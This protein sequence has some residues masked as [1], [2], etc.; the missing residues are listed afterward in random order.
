MM[1]AEFGHTMG[2][3]SLA[4][5]RRAQIL[6]AL[7]TCILRFGLAGST[8]GRIA[9]EAGVQPSVLH[10]YFQNKDAVIA[11]AVERMLDAYRA[12]FQDALAERTGADRL[13]AL[14]DFLFGGG[15]IRQQFEIIMGELITVAHRDAPTRARIRAMYQEYE[16]TCADIVADAYPEAAAEARARV[17]YALMCLADANATFTGLE[18]GCERHSHAREMAE[19]LLATLR[20][21]RNENRSAPR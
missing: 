14:L 19:A 9:A 2:R 8:V 18:I 21:P 13:P 10:H 1:S 6:E 11:A 15:F 7:E 12:V 3:K 16:R 5:Q 20:A 4:P 17:A